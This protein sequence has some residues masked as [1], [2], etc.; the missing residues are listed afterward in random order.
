MYNIL[1]PIFEFIGWFFI[2]FL[3][4][5]K[6][7]PKF[8]L[9]CCSKKYK[10]YTKTKTI[11]QYLQ[12]YCGPAYL[13]HYK[14]SSLINIIFITFM[15]GAGLPVLYFIALASFIL[16]Y[17]LE[18]ILVAYSYREPPLFDQTLHREALK[19]IKFAGFIYSALAFWMLGNHQI[20]G[21][22]VYYLQKYN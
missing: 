9:F 17:I 18:R 6:D 12:I 21:T 14:Y 3:K 22:D 15:F 16:Q 19:L 11:S 2:R 4:R 1:W 20:F 8:Y 5:L 13:I 7:N 10:F